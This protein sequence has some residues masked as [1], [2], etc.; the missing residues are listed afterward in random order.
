[1][2]AAARRTG[3]TKGALTPREREV[4]ALIAEGFSNRQIATRLVIS[5]RTAE[6]H[7]ERIMGKL[8]VRNRA[9]IAAKVGAA[10]RA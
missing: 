3:S 5:E 10:A 4:A 1:M 8:A 7:V 2:P 6:S 9:E